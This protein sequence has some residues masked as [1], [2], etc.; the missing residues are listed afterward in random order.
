[1]LD[2]YPIKLETKGGF[3]SGGYERVVITCAHDP[4]HEFTY[5]GDDNAQVVHEDI[6]QLIRRLDKIIELRIIGGVTQEVDVTGLFRSECGLPI[7]D[8]D[9]GDR[10]IRHS[11]ILGIDV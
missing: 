10:C 5:K 4:L 8:A 1:M 9:I 11:A 3:V 6:S 2:G 7:T